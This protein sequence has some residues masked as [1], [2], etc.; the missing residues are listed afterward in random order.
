M[1]AD[2][3]RS[4]LSRTSVT[5]GLVGGIVHAGVAVFLW[6]HFGFDSPWDMLATKPLNG[7]YVVLG[8]FLLGFV[9][10]LFYVGQKVVSPALVVAVFLLLSGLGSWLAGPVGAPSA[11]PTPFAV[12]ILFWVAGLTGR[13]EYRRKRR[14]TG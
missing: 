14:A 4:L 12:Y 13:L 8:M 6:N 7:A 11:V 5:G 9:P 2:S 10:V 1:G 3:E